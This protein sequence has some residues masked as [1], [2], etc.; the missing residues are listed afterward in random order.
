MITVNKSGIGFSIVSVPLELRQDIESLLKDWHQADYN[1]TLKKDGKVVDNF[2]EV[3][4][5]RAVDS[6]RKY[7]YLDIATTGVFLLDK[8]DH[9]IWCI[10]AYGVKH[11]Q[12]YVGKLTEVTGVELVKKRWMKAT[13]AE[14]K[15]TSDS[16]G[17]TLVDDLIEKY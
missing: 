9:T 7:V 4:V 15:D 2:D 8:E 17:Q 1:E 13:K 16:E 11:P 6:G 10:K 3:S 12:K 5:K 14:R